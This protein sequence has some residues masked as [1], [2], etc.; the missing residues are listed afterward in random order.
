MTSGR[1]QS[2]LASPS[3][4]SVLYCPYFQE[5][6]VNAE[7]KICCYIGRPVWRPIYCNRAPEDVKEREKERDGDIVFHKHWPDSSILGPHSSYTQG[8]I[9]VYNSRESSPHLL[10]SSDS[11]NVL[12]GISDIH[13]TLPGRWPCRWLLWTGLRKGHLLIDSSAEGTHALLRLSLIRDRSLL[14]I[15]ENANMSQAFNSRLTLDDFMGDL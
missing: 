1:M 8:P 7:K 15:R 4:I 6:T 9:S 5:V 12:T 3:P 14:W 11:A 10:K 13:A 2:A